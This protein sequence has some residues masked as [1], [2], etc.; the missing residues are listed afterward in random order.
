M[1]NYLVKLGFIFDELSMNFLD[2]TLDKNKNNKLKDFGK[3]IP[4]LSN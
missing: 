1:I 3:K 2:N 4:E